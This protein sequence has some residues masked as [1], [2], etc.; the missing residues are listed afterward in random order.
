MLLPAPITPHLPPSWRQTRLSHSTLALPKMQ[1][2]PFPNASVLTRIG[3][4]LHRQIRT[5]PSPAC[6]KQVPWELLHRT[7]KA[8]LSAFPRSF[9][10]P[11]SF[12]P[13]SPL[14]ASATAKGAASCHLSLP[15]R[16][17]AVPSFF[18]KFCPG[19]CPPPSFSSSFS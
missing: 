3:L 17:N 2:V 11:N 1:A 15:S 10:D 4:C 14:P 5:F 8:R 9:T 16:S 6:P 7:L 19:I 12:P 13:N 18:R